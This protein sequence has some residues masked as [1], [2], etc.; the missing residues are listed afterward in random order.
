VTSSLRGDRRRDYAI[1]PRSAAEPGIMTITAVKVRGA[2]LAVMRD[3]AACLYYRGAGVDP[4]HS[5]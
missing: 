4:S 5:S 1:V 3:R 2:R